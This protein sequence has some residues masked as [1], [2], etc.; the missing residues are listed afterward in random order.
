MKKVSLFA[1]ALI[2]LTFASCSVEPVTYTLEEN[3]TLTWH[4]EEHAEHFHNGTLAIT[5]GSLT[6]EGDK[7]T[8]GSF[9]IDMNSLKATTEG[10]PTEKVAY[11]EGHLKSDEFFNTAKY[12]EANVK[13]NGYENGKL[14]TT[15][16]V[17]GVEL[18]NDI[19]VSLKQTENSVEIKGEF[20]MDISGTKMPYLE[21]K[22]EETG[23]AALNPNLQ[24]TL[25][26]KLKK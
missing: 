18:T 14:N 23:E 21:K 15:I 13:V 22:N 10:L 20:S 1:L 3:S 9:V 24:F 16:T 5:S 12:G 4:G 8:D 19:P 11:L 25:D 6:M 17:L 26:I 2:G 7:V